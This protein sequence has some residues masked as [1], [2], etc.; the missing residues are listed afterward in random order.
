MFPRIRTLSHTRI[1]LALSG[2]LAITFLTPQMGSPAS[3]LSAFAKSNSTLNGKNDVGTAPVCQGQGALTY[4]PNVSSWYLDSYVPQPE[5]EAMIATYGR[6]TSWYSTI[7]P[8]FTEPISHGQ[9]GLAGTWITPNKDA[10]GPIENHTA[11]E[12]K[13]I[14]QTI[15]GGSGWYTDTAF[16]TTMPKFAPG[17][18][19]NDY[20]TGALDFWAGQP[21]KEGQG[22][23]ITISNRILLPPEGM[24][25]DPSSAGA[26][27]GQTWLS[28]PLPKTGTALQASSGVTAGTN[29][30]T[31]FL[32]TANFKGPV[33]YVEPN[34]WAQSVA[35]YPSLSG[36]TFDNQMGRSY[37]LDGEFAA[38]PICT[39]VDSKGV[40]Y[41]RIPQLQFPTDAQGRFIFA[42]D[43]RAYSNE[44]IAKALTTSIQSNS[45]LPTSFD[46]AGV[47]I[48]HLQPDPHSTAVFQGGDS[49]PSLISALTMKKFDGG[50]AVGLD[51]GVANSNKVLPNY[52]VKNGSTRTP[53]DSTSA[54]TSLQSHDFT[55]SDNSYHRVYQT[56]PWF[57]AAGTAASADYKTNLSDGS[58]VTYRW[59]KFIDQP[60]F[61]R[62]HLTDSEKKTMQALA[63][64]MQR[65]WVNDPLQDAP[66][67]GSLVKFDSGLLVKPPAGLE[68]GYVPVV[69][70][71][72][73]TYSTMP[74]S[75]AFQTGSG[76]PSATPT[77]KPTPTPT[78]SLTPTSTPTPTPS[79]T[80]TST[81]TPTPSLTPTSTPTPKYR[82]R[83][84][85]T[86]VHGK[87][88]RRISGLRP[89]CPSGYSKK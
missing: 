56:L 52:F 10:K 74:K 29:A 87:V 44:A 63:E 70:R 84:T 13:A 86:C 89:K 22:G 1:A 5:D 21:I 64:K 17:P 23:W 7:W 79:L 34:L 30:W 53:V 47:Q 26:Q 48:R 67:G 57:G 32:N 54:P 85:I 55:P 6:G 58:T 72:E 68:I 20:R 8:L 49:V 76:N 50:A 81:S 37:V 19:V 35:A 14:T 51:I 59:Y 40:T 69:I 88:S 46:S 39:S 18:T 75:I 25:F 31:L 4:T 15:E 43:Y 61:A 73:N 42:R 9:A 24:T 62:Y 83:T 38:I 80:P 36:L 45:A 16:R 2:L 82:N 11:D 33:G 71:Q 66:S 12:Q 65:Q 77:P 28:L 3:A 27:L 60:Q 41:S 78:P